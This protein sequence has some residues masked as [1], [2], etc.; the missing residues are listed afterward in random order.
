M[1]PAP[2]EVLM[3]GL[4]SGSWAQVVANM[5][6]LSHLTIV[7]INDGYTELIRERPEVKSLLANPRVTIEID[8]GRRWIL[9]HPER[10]FDFVVMN[11]TFHYRAHATNLLSADFLRIARGS[12]RPGGILFYNTTSSGDVVKTGATVFPHAL[13]FGNF[14]AV[15][16]SPIVIDKQ[17]WTERLVAW[18][19]DGARVLDPS[20]EAGQRKLAETMALADSVNGPPGDETLE[21]RESLLRTHAAY[22]LITDDNMQSEWFSKYAPH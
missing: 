17:R 7:E 19:I 16:D 10:T 13:R 12:M 6:G 3:I 21:G 18:E 2:A 15:S 11:T 14:L 22:T 9:R 20:T 8:D 1:H 4:S 5:P